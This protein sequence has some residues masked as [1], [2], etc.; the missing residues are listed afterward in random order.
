MQKRSY[1]PNSQRPRT[2]KWAK[3]QTPSLHLSEI[4]PPQ[5]PNPLPSSPLLSYLATLSANSRTTMLR[6]ADNLA[7]AAS[8]GQTTA[9]EYDWSNLNVP[10]ATALRAWCLRNVEHSTWQATTAN[11]HI[12]CLRGIA[13]AAWRLDLLNRDTYEKIRDLPSLR[14]SRPLAGREVPTQERHAL[15]AVNW[16]TPL[17]TTRNQLVLAL[18]YFSGLRRGEIAALTLDNIDIEQR[19]LYV[20]GKGDKVRIVPIAPQLSN[21]LETW[22]TIRGSN[23]GY[24]VCQIRQRTLFLDK[25]LSGEAIRQI[26]LDAAR[27]AGTPPLSPHDLR[28]TFAGD[29]LDAGADLVTLSTLMGHASPSTTARYDRRGLR[30]A[31]EAIEK[32]TL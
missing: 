1:D 9:L 4:Q 21:T 6:C 19:E 3:R 17:F 20:H 25:P 12:A 28:R 26:V 22:M 32:L 14:T 10:L 2:R 16:S 31:R 8:S 15:F 23:P 27:R 5:A 11:L 29:L 13:K 18:L 7:W 24:L 30:A